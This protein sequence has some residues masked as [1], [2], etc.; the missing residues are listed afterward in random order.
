MPKPYLCAPSLPVQLL[1][2]QQAKERLADPTLC[3][4]IPF[5][6]H[7]LGARREFLTAYDGPLV[8]GVAGLVRDSHRVPGALGVSFIST[9]CDHLNRG[10]ATALVRALFDLAARRGQDIANTAYEPDGHK[11]LRPVLQR[12]AR[13]YPRVQLHEHPST[14]C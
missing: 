14:P 12:V 9:H 13:E 10:V 8:V 2:P 6:K 4:N 3:E 7:D 5:L 11:W 1:S